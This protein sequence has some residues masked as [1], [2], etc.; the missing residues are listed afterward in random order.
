MAP[1][2]T[3][4]PGPTVKIA[5]PRDNGV[6]RSRV[7]SPR[8]LEQDLQAKRGYTEFRHA[9]V[10]GG[11]WP[12]EFLPIA[13]A[14]DAEGLDQAQD[15]EQE[16]G[17]TVRVLRP[18]H[19]VATALSVGRP[20]DHVRIAF[21]IG[22]FLRTPTSRPST[23]K[24]STFWWRLSAKVP[25]CPLRPILAS[26]RTKT[27]YRVDFCAGGYNF[28]VNPSVTAAPPQPNPGATLPATECTSRA[29]FSHAA[30]QPCRPPGSRN[31]A[32]A[33]GGPAGRSVRPHMAGG[34]AL[35]AEEDGAATCKSRR[36]C[37]AR[38]RDERLSVQED[39]QGG[40][41]AA[42]H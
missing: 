8:H 18:Q 6:A 35:A 15:V 36:I 34:Q 40:A 33:A 26:A 21:G 11:G 7:R 24:T 20:K 37:R 25:A 30:R 28:G 14:L 31:K 22:D 9:G 42:R 17:L 23:P 10:V 19:L 39:R 27:R 3:V 41:Y 13:T 29:G 5:G 2:L 32:L 12:V 16:P 1:I 38:D 4:S